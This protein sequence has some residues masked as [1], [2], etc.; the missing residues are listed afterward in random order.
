VDVHDFRFEF[1][2]RRQDLLV[3]GGAH[4]VPAELRRRAQRV[5]GIFQTKSVYFMPSLPD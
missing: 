5:A 3:H 4:D 2:G 1:L